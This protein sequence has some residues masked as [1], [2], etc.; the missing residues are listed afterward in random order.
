MLIQEM[1]NKIDINKKK[2]LVVEIIF[3]LFFWLSLPIFLAHTQLNISIAG[4]FN[5]YDEYYNI[6]LF[7]GTICNAIL[8]YLLVFVVIPHYFS[9]NKYL[10]GILAS[11]LLYI[12][13]G[14]FEFILDYIV[15]KSI[16]SATDAERIFSNSGIFLYIS[17]FEIN[18]LFL[19]T[20]IAYR[21]TKDWFKSEKIKHQLMEEKLSSELQFLKSQINPHLLFN[22]LNNLFGMARQAKAIPVADGIAKLSNLMRY[23]IYDS[24]IDKVPIE[25][26]IKYINDFI[27][28]QKLRIKYTNNINIDFKISNYSPKLIIAPLILIPFVEN[29]FKHGISSQNR[30]E[31]IIELKT[32]ENKVDFNICNTINKLR[33]NRNDESSGFGLKNVKKRLNLIYPNKH[34]LKINIEDN[35]Y[36][37]SLAID[38]EP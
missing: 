12:L 33:I 11:L 9:R 29:S 22:T 21:F 31:I 35:F 4:V 26:E 37:V 32:I 36:T 30:S 3:H 28:L 23:M 16:Y 13:I 27:D 1:E 5:T 8:F 19:I 20:A 38:T 2:I 6:T 34:Q 10:P 14:F 17:N 18:V 7:Y 25:K 15:L 24:V